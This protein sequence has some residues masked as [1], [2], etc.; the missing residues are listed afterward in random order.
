MLT[1]RSATDGGVDPAVDRALEAALRRLRP[2]DPDPVSRTGRWVQ[3]ALSDGLLDLPLP[4]RGRT[5]ARLVALAAFGRV[6]LD[7]ARLAE[8]HADAMAILDDLG[9]PAAGPG[10]WGVWAANPPVDPLR[11]ERAGDGWTL[12]GTKPWCSGAGTCERA[13]VTASTRDGYRLFAVSMDAATVT[14][15]DG[16]WP[17]PA[18]RGSDSR[19]V[20]FT[21][22]PAVAV[23]DPEDYLDRP[24]FWYG[25]VG[26]AAVWLGG[27]QAV[28]ERLAVAHARRPLDPHALAHAGAVDAMLS[29]AEALLLVEAAA[30]FD[31]DPADDRGTARLVAGRVRAVVERTAAEVIDRVGRALGAAPLALDAEHAQRVADLAL[32]LRQSHAERDLEELGRRALDERGR[33]W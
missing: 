15:V 16:T 11:A 14:A 7:L 27:A 18:M 2:D 29:A 17:A 33:R 22:H 6:D 1:L 23:G 12:E 24:G 21:S 25:A 31:R 19:S 8:G 10:L 5:P 20:R 13:L 28:A 4:G 32:Y 3:D 30:G 9:L 26:V